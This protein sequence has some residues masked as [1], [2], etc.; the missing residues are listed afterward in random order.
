[1]DHD[2]ARL[3]PP[4]EVICI[5]GR[6][7]KCWIGSRRVRPPG[8]SRF[9]RMISSIGGGLSPRPWLRYTGLGRAS[10]C[11]RHTAASRT[12]V[13]IL[14]SGHSAF[15]TNCRNDRQHSV[16][17]HSRHSAVGGGEDPE[18]KVFFSYK[19]RKLFFLKKI[20]KIWHWNLFHQ[21]Q[22]LRQFH[23]LGFAADN[24]K[25]WKTLC[26]YKFECF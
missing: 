23:G 15:A 20:H 26:F 21:H 16:F 8:T 2:F 1:M 3:I 11:R 9:P 4:T 12:A 13:V 10:Y 22:Q 24:K 19:I 17:W 6:E 7:W 18:K 25:K 14:P 5:P